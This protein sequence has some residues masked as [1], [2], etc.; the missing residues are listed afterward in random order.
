MTV[1]TTKQKGNEEMKVT[2]LETIFERVGLT[3]GQIEATARAAVKNA[4]RFKIKQ[5]SGR[6]RPRCICGKEVGLKNCT[7][8]VQPYSWQEERK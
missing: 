3:R 7:P 4:P 5:K 6:P 8:F 1:K 2:S